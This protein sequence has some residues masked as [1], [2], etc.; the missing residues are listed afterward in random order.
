MLQTVL[1]V[2]HILVAFALIAFILIQQGKGATTG[3]AFGSG[4]STTVFGAR[5]SGSFLTR[6]TAVLAFVFF[7]NC[8]F[9]AYLSKQSIAPTS[10]VE[11]VGAPAQPLTMP[12]PAPV[13]TNN[14]PERADVPSIP[15]D[16]K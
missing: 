4:A 11:R 2:V 15:S 1:L 9:L 5:G 16:T 6:T 7:G 12:A 8:M 10:V 3:A 13:P 14:A